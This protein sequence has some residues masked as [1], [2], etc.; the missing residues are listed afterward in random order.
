MKR[1]LKVI[2]WV[3]GGMVVLVGGCFVVG[4]IGVF[5]PGTRLTDRPLSLSEFNREFGGEDLPDSASNIWYANAATGGRSGVV[6]LYRF[7]APFEDCIA[8]ANLLIERNNKAYGPDLQFG[9]DLIPIDSELIPIGKDVLYRDSE[10]I[11]R[12]NEMLK[13]LGLSKVDWFDIE[14]IANGLTVGRPMS[15]PSRFWIDTDRNRFY[16]CWWD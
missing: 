2:S 3:I 12:D 1:L 11:L 13:R 9:K 7:D 8:H 15:H 14:N 10:R 4:Q 6:I 16:Y 5:L